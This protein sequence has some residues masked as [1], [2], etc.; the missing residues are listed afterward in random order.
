MPDRF[1]AE[2]WLPSRFSLGTLRLLGFAIA[3]VLERR[4]PSSGAFL[5]RGPHQHP[6]EATLLS[7]A[8]WLIPSVQ[9]TALLGRAC[10]WTWYAV[11]LGFAAM[12]VAVPV[13]WT[14]VA[15]LL[16]P[17]AAAA[18][19]LTSRATHDIQ[20]LVTPTG[21]LLLAVASVVL[22]WPAAPLG[23]LWIAL[24]II[25]IA[26]SLACFALRGAFAALERRLP[27]VAP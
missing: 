14:L 17:A 11:P 26:S 22:D 20:A 2:E 19:R 8:Y 5:N 21:M 4:R 10:A 3:R 12:L 15:L 6:L 24:T 1:F 25:E 18:S 27:Q 16:T 13:M 7:L 9:L 23:W